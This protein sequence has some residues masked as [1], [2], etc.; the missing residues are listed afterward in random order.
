M[1]KKRLIIIAPYFDEVFRSVISMQ[2]QNLAKN[3]SC[4]NIALVKLPM[5]STSQKNYAAD[6][7]AIIGTQMALR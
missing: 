6:F 5:A 2:V 1:D 4:A 3:G 7:A